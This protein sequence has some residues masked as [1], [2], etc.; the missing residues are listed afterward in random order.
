M[1]VPLP[2]AVERDKGVHPM[3]QERTVGKREKSHHQVAREH[4]DAV[5]YFVCRVQGFYI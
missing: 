5:S 4:L 1:H 2:F 3:G